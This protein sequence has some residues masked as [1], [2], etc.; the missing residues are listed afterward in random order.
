MDPRTPNQENLVTPTKDHRGPETTNRILNGKKFKSSGS[1]K[2]L[3]KL[4]LD[5]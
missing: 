5:Q 1:M 4:V 3:T 2:E